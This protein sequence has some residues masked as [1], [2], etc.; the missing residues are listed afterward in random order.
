M[1]KTRSAPHGSLRAIRRRGE[2]KAL[3]DADF[4]SG[5]TSIRSG[6]ASSSASASA[7]SAR[8]RSSIRMLLEKG[9][10][11]V[12]P[13]F[14]PMMIAN[15][16][17][18]QISMLTGAKGP[19]T[20]DGHRVR[21]RHAFDRRFVQDDSARRRRRHDLRRSGSDDPSESGWLDSA[22]CAR[23]RPATT[24]RKGEPSVRRGS[25]R[26]R[27]GRRLRRA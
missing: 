20:T 24:S 19:N 5:R 10:K 16:A 3:Q 4:R 18:G 23:C 21:D 17:S 2:Q 12:S 15:M 25:G 9:P 13:F 14:I 22:P 26:L 6:S 11:R 27:H 8:G 7:V 1:D